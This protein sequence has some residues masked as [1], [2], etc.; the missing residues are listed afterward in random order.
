MLYYIYDIHVT[1]YNVNGVL[2]TVGKHTEN[3]I[4]LQLKNE[5]DNDKLDIEVIGINEAYRRILRENRLLENNEFNNFEWKMKTF[6]L[7]SFNKIIAEIKSGNFTNNINKQGVINIKENSMK[8]VYHDGQITDPPTSTYTYAP[9]IS[10][11]TDSPTV[12]PPTD[13]PTVA[14]PTDP[15]TLTPTLSPTFRTCIYENEN[16]KQTFDNCG[17]HRITTLQGKSQEDCKNK[18][19]QHQDCVAASFNPTVNSGTCNLFSK[20]CDI[21]AADESIVLICVTEAP[22]TGAPTTGAPTVSPTGSPTPAPTYRTCTYD[23]TPQAFDTCSDFKIGDSKQSFTPS[24][25]RDACEQDPE[26]VAASFNTDNKNCNLFN[27]ECAKQTPYSGAI[28]IIRCDTAT[29]TNAPTAPTAPPTDSP[30]N[31]PINATYAP[32]APPP[33]TGSPTPPTDAPTD[34]PTGAPTPPTDAPTAHPTDP[35]TGAPTPPTNS[36][37]LSPTDPPTGAP[38]PPTNA[39]TATPT[40]A[41]TPPTNAPTATPTDPPTD[42]PTDVPTVSPTPNPTFK[43][44]EFK[45]YDVKQACE[46]DPYFKYNDTQYEADECK[47]K[48]EQDILCVVATYNKDKKICNVFDEACVYKTTTASLAVLTCDT[49]SP[50]SAPTLLPTNAPTLA[51]TDSPTDAPTTVAPTPPTNA[52]TSSP[53]PLCTTE[54]NT[55]IPTTCTTDTNPLLY[56]RVVDESIPITSNIDCKI[57][58]Q[59]D[60]ECYSSVY[61]VETNVCRI[62]GDRSGL[63]GCIKVSRSNFHLNICRP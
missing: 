8:I 34:P 31:A 36:P 45:N 59:Q 37:T 38:T 22:T 20:Q 48:C 1:K 32:T 39:P 41:P 19:E 49:Q 60:P 63:E 30:T 25:C 47:D 2:E 55:N 51:P 61:G 54:A 56:Y 35:P 23:D 18:C 17:D 7:K 3:T 29:P 4:E 62:Y 42:A 24:Q 6:S 53:T 50:T 58:C 27:T 13:P 5:V 43:S 26:C 9:T 57:Q 21:K 46:G 16:T 10:S 44:C 33:I 15:P 11:T 28:R 14:P 52:P 40:G 12:A